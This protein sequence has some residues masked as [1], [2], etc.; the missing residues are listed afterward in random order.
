M[1]DVKQARKDTKLIHGLDNGRFADGAAL[2]APEN[3][4]SPN[5][6][7]PHEEQHVLAFHGELPRRS[8]MEIPPQLLNV[9]SDIYLG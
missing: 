9:C 3:C 5:A 4:T 1:S 8:P 6:A 7:Q 2:Y